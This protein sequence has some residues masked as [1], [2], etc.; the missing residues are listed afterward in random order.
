[1]ILIGVL[2]LALAALVFWLPVLLVY[3]AL[4]LCAWLGIVLLAKGCKLYLERN[5]KE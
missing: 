3:P 5:R 2:F 1:M 4:V